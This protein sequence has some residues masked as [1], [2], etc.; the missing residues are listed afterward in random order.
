LE[1]DLAS[2]LIDLEQELRK[3][4]LHLAIVR[5]DKD[6]LKKMKKS[7]KAGALTI[8]A[9][10]KGVVYDCLQEIL[11]LLSYGIQEDLIRL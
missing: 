2:F 6:E 3:L 10:D 1:Q 11:R 9:W 8:F 5:S 4:D 7:E